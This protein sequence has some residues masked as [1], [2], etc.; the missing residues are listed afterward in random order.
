MIRPSASA[1]EG[2]LSG[3]LSFGYG[4]GTRGARVRWWY[5]IR[6]SPSLQI[7]LVILAIYLL[8]AVVGQIYTPYNPERTFVGE[9]FEAP[10]STF[11]FGTDRL[12]QDVFS[13]TLAA[14]ALDIR[15]AVLAVAAAVTIGVT[16]G[17]VI[18]YV[19]GTVDYL[20]MRVLEIKAAFPG[21]IF[22]L[23]VVSA[24]GPGELN[25]VVVLAFGSFPIYSR[26]VRAELISRKNWQYAEAARMVGCSPMR[27]AFRHLLPN[28]IGPALAYTSVSA[29]YA[30]LTVASLGYLGVGL[31]PGT[32]EWGAMIARGQPQIVT[33]Q[34]W[35]SFFPGL[36]L[37]ILTA[38]FYLVGDGL[39]DALDPRT[40]R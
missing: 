32:A 6:Q 9:R 11:W 33:G 10:N 31:Q 3:E 37:L 7:G 21:L 2:L 14:A 18:G 5:I 4:D 8:A 27:V 36:T 40:H 12:G 38:G 15:I 34:W 30:I 39:R 20:T 24:L 28:S 17:A 23:I 29:A 13:R 1:E 25:V 19:G 16:I 35:V 26:L 22:A